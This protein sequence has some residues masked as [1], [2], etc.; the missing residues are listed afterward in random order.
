MARSSRRSGNPPRAA[1]TKAQCTGPNSA[2][3]TAATALASPETTFLIALVLAI[4]SLR[5][6]VSTASSR[7]PAAAP[8][9]PT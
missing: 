1:A 7:M 5:M 8:K 3:P 4:D 6:G 2:K 9:Y